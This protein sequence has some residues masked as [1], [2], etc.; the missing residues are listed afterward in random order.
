M[1]VWAVRSGK[2]EPRI[3]IAMLGTR[4]RPVTGS[5]ETKIGAET[6]WDESGDISQQLRQCEWM[7][8]VRTGL[9]P[10]TGESEKLCAH[11][12]FTSL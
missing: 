6:F 10:D 12:H 11:V 9:N 2:P 3:V 7:C 5:A 1:D 8:M 4:N